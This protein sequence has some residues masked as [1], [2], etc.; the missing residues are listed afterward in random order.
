MD[1]SPTKDRSVSGKKLV[2]S[3]TDTHPECDSCKYVQNNEDENHAAEY[4]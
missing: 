4:R 3:P 2:I 1:P